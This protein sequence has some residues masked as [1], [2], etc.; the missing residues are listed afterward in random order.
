[1]EVL[2]NQLCFFNLQFVLQ[3]AHGTYNTITKDLMFVCPHCPIS[4]IVGP[5]ITRISLSMHYKDLF[6]F[7]PHAKQFHF[8]SCKKHNKKHTFHTLKELLAYMKKVL[9]IYQIPHLEGRPTISSEGIEI[10]VLL[11]RSEKY[12]FL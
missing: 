5:F 8:K 12:C 2:K 10:P 9:R 7:C 1:M 4:T 3:E 6:S 11:N